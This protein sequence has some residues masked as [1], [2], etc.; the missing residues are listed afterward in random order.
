MQPQRDPAYAIETKAEHFDPAL[1]Q[2]HRILDD[3]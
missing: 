2:R 3:R 1:P